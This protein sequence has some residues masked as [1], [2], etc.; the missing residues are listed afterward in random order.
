MCNRYYSITAGNS[1]DIFALWSEQRMGSNYRD[2]NL[3]NGAGKAVDAPNGYNEN[4]NDSVS[5]WWFY[6]C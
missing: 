3:R 4:H 5:S 2:P 1:A 6:D